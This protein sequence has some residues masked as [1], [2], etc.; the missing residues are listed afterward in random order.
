MEKENLIKYREYLWNYFSLH[1]DQRL[2][3]F[4]FYLV[5][6]TLIV[7]AFVNIINSNN[8]QKIVFILPYLLTFISFVFWKLDLRTKYMIKNAED[9]IKYID[10]EIITQK[11]EIPKILNIFRYD[12][13][14]SRSLRRGFIKG[15]FSYSK[16]FN[17][18]FISFGIM[19]FILGTLYLINF[20][21]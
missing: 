14:S 12:E 2:R 19:G 4:N 11:G 21:K 5:V 20:I 1:A 16:S 10:D 8:E 18:I 13:F 3:T 9:A 6:S 7:G 15:C 17:L